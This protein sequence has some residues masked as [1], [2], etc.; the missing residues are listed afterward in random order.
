[1]VN[2]VSVL[3]SAFT[4]LFLFWSIS[5]FARKIVGK[6]AD[7][8]NFAET[9][10][11]LGSSLVGALTYTFSDTFWFSAVEAEVYGMSSFFTAIVIWAALHW[12]LIEDEA[13]E[14]RWLIFTAYLVGL[15]I[16]VHLL[17]LLAIPALAL[18]YYY[19]KAKKVSN[20]G[21]F[22][23]FMVG[24]VILGI[25]NVGLITGLPSIGFMFE[26]LFVNAM[27]LPFN[28]GII[29]FVLL[30][31]SAL[32]FGIYYTNKKGKVIANTAL[33]SFA[34]I[35]IGYSTYT[36]AL[37]RSN[38]NPPINEN[39]PSNTLN[40]VSYLK[41]EQYGSRPLL[42]GPVFSSQLT[43]ITRN[44]S[45]P[46]YKIDNKNGK[47]AIY[48]YKPSY[49]WMAG[50]QMILPRVWSSD[51]NH[52]EIYR[53][54]LNLAPEQKPSLADNIKF[55]FK[56]QFGH[57]Y[58]RYFMW[59]FW[60]R[61]SDI[62]SSG[63]VNILEA[64]S[65]LPSP[66][67]ENRG[68]TNFFGIPLILGL[69]GAI[70]QLFKRDRDF[71]V[72]LLL[73]LFM[74]LALVVF[75]N[76]PPVEPRERDYIYVGSFYIWA[77][78]IGIGVMAL[79]DWVLKFIKNP[80]YRAGVATVASLVAIPVMMAPQTWKGHDRSNRYHQVDFAKNLLN[81]VA[82]N[83]ILFTGGD[84]DTFPLWYAQEVEGV[85]T[86][87]RV[88][89][90]SLLG[91]DWYIDQMKRKT[92]QSEAL[93]I[94]FEFD[95]YISGINDQLLFAEKT[96]EPIDLKQYMQFV[97]TNNQ[98]IQE[99][100]MTGDFINTLPSKQ[101]S[102]NYD[103]EAVKSLGFIPKD[104]EELLNG[105]VKWEIGERSLL[106]NDLIMLDII[107][108]NNWKRPIYYAGTLSSENYL[109]LKEY[110]QLEGYAYRLMPF[111]VE[112]ASDGFVNTDIM[113]KNMKTKMAWREMQNPNVY[114]DSE[115]Y[116]KVPIIT[117]RYAFLRLVDELTR[118]G[119]KTKAL[120]M[121]DYANKVLPDNT[122][123]YDQLC[124]NYALFYFENGNAKKGLEIADTMAK[125]ADEMLG[126]FTSN[127]GSLGKQTQWGPNNVGQFTQFNMRILQ[128]LSN[129]AE[130]NNQPDA[131]KRYKAIFDKYA[132][133]VQG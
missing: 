77:I 34:F 22:I 63:P 24:M 108:Q 33:L 29:F 10:I 98:L 131:A 27:G 83:A 6:K 18:I 126:Y 11:V 19:K 58:F 73:F 13:A 7:E 12:E 64:K 128:V 28:T 107:A 95:Q 45:E 81:S 112:G 114:Y 91:T 67:R 72:N 37:I 104:K 3:S 54:N 14:N 96:K 61:A 94:S 38:Y 86:D 79:A 100:V 87:V 53:S 85:R 70:Y 84:N 117:A 89:N 30:L 133:R 88:C 129:I 21:M 1:M 124:A 60:G 48:D 132:G 36:I 31:V 76:S 25:I 51:P 130:Q 90:L 102:L 69:L 41:R 101:L 116:L 125:R 99:Q 50:S 109:N 106:K 8:L 5:L 43:G 39:N 110:M 97:K 9:I 93:P 105:Q 57:M 71:I 16:G 56:F 52:Q 47:Y 35:L 75:L 80:T 32:V 127:S 111:K 115:T 123:P 23:A 74:G 103:I 78:W 26:R 62:E 122:I 59:N 119:D 120:E 15:S 20:W 44:T 42:Y 66:L 17:N 46:L 49:E 4:I 65:S 82:P 68:R 118:Q 2:M 121:L 92:Y 40:Y 55:M 113:Y